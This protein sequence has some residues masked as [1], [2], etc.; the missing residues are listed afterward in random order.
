VVIWAHDE[1]G[2][3]NKAATPQTTRLLMLRSIFLSLLFSWACGAR[4]RTSLLVGAV[5]L[6]GGRKLPLRAGKCNP[7][8]HESYPLDVLSAELYSGQT[9]ISSEIKRVSNKLANVPFLPSPES[10]C[11]AASAG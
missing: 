9:S 3:R 2:N 7:C 10:A 1:A 8:T 6:N 11:E 4:R 5:S